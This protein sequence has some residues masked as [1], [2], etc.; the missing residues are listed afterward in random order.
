MPLCNLQRENF[1]SVSWLLSLW[2]GEVLIQSRNSCRGANTSERRKAKDSWD[3]Q[4]PTLLAWGSVCCS[5]P[6]PAAGQL[7]TEAAL[8]QGP[9]DSGPHHP[10]VGWGCSP[11]QIALEVFPGENGPLPRVSL[12]PLNL[13]PCMLPKPWTPSGPV[14]SGVGGGGGGRGLC[15]WPH[16]VSRTSLATWMVMPGPHGGSPWRELAPRVH[17]SCWIYLKWL[18]LLEMF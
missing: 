14:G 6:V 12:S 11:M 3:P 18:H 16:A 8:Q 9:R 1:S 15:L 17:P 10:E 5:C 13:H 2:K 7:C 4:N